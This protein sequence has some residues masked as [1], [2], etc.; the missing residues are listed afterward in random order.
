[1]GTIYPRGQKLW[2]GYRDEHNEWQY[3]SSG[4]NVGQEKQAQKV[5]EKIEARIAAGVDAGSAL[6]PITLRRYGE[7]WT[8]K[9]KGRKVRSVDAD[10][11]RLKKHVYPHIGAILLADIRPRHIVHLIEDLRSSG[12]LAPRTVH[13]VYGVLHVLFRDAQID[14]LIDV[15]PCVLTR[16]QLGLKEDKNPEWRASAIY[17]REELEFLIS[18]PLIPR[19]RQIMY[20]LEGLAGLRHG[21]AVGLRWRNYETKAEPLGQLVI[22][23]SYD[24]ASTKTGRPRLMPVHPT[25]AAMLAEWKM[26]GWTEM[27][28]GKPNQD[29]LIIPSRTGEMRSRHHSR[30]KLL[31][32]LKRLGLRARRGHDLRR[33]FITL[34]RVDGARA[35]LLQ[36]VTHNP[37]NDIIN[38]YTSMPWPSLCAEVAKLS[39]QR[40][41]GELVMLPVAA[42]GDTTE[43]AAEPP[44]LTT[45]RTTVQNTRKKDPNKL[46]DVRPLLKR[47]L[48]EAPGIEPGSENA[49][50]SAST[51][52]ADLLNRPGSRQS[53]GSHPGYCPVSPRDSPGHPMS[54]QPD[55]ITPFPRCRLAS[56]SDG[57]RGFLGRESDCVIVRN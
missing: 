4:F 3:S 20:A 42:N 37:T 8:K 45:V 47:V 12:K 25:L 40:R 49:L 53:A 21:E 38:I 18:S 1:M 55:L 9:R 13:H 28:G 56:G 50:L 32:D 44:A 57:Y 52:V 6:G 35:D 31:D 34:A 33:T 10:E 26:S 29:D 16:W 11:G 15:N 43:P 5:L 51:C 39:V 23:R 41:K 22:A 17:T 19:D 24:N 30:N 48:V 14:E 46:W 2:V 54:H 7:Q 36:M 27:L